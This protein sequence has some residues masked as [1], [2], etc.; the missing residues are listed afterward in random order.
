MVNY[1]VFVEKTISITSIIRKIAPRKSMPIPLHLE[2]T[3]T[4]QARPVVLSKVKD[5]SQFIKLR[6]TSLVIF[7][8]AAGYLLAAETINYFDFAM[9]ILGGL[10]VTGASNG[11]NQII[12]RR[13]DKLMLRTAE[14]PLPQERMTVTE[15]LIL[16]SILGLAGIVVLW[17]FLNPLSAALGALAMVLYTIV[18]TPMK[19][20]T[21]FAVFVGAFPG[22]IPP[23]IGWAAYSGD[24]SYGAWM[25]FCIQFMWQFPHFWAIAWR[26]DEDYKRAGFK[27]LPSGNR[28]KA[29]AFQILVYTIGLIPVSLI[30]VLFGL[31]G[32]VSLALL[33]VAGIVFLY[34]AI[35]LYNTLSPE[36]ASRLMFGSFIYLPVAQLA[37]LIDKL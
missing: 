11:F 33:L 6:L 30:P 26:L 32:Y 29:S 17:Y 22:S 10:L 20:K 19:K 21:P 14:R 15:G 5:Y 4:Y 27:M 18:Y 25:L 34:Q 2:E 31:T 13:S 37:L 8:A 23:L 16:A 3:A 35:R 24:L 1:R 28:D 12:E 7:S 9:L 36:A